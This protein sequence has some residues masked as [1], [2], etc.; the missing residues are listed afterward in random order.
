MK[1]RPF[2]S[3]KTENV[4]VTNWKVMKARNK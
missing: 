2:K 1:K 3:F 4:I